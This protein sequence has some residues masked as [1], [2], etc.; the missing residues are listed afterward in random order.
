MSRQPPVTSP[1]PVLHQHLGKTPWQFGGA[2]FDPIFI[3]PS[4]RK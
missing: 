4:Q 1:S 2:C 3:Y